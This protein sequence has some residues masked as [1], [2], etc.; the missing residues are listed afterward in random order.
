MPSGFLGWHRRATRGEQEYPFGTTPRPTFPCEMNSANAVA[1]SPPLGGNASRTRK[2]ARALFCRRGIFRSGQLF[3]C[4][5]D[6]KDVFGAGFTPE[7]YCP[8]GFGW[9][10]L[11]KVQLRRL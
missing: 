10:G 4:N 7:L 5:G 9:V 8:Q 6:R 2:R 11:W 1:S 3:A